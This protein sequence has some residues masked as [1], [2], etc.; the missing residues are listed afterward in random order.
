MLLKRQGTHRGEQLILERHSRQGSLWNVGA[1]N[2]G[3]ARSIYGPDGD[4][5]RV[6]AVWT[7]KQID[8]LAHNDGQVHV[9]KSLPIG[10]ASNENKISLSV[11]CHRVSYFK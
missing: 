5:Y 7:A 4:L 9:E 2:G 6:I 11:C 1:A 10:C 8:A 3:C